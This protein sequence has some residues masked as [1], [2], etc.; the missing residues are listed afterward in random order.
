MTDT[1]INI[2]QT[3]RMRVVDFARTQLLPAANP[4]TSLEVYEPAKDVPICIHELPAAYP[5]EDHDDFFNGGVSDSNILR[6]N[7]MYLRVIQL[8]EQDG[9]LGFG[10]SLAS[11]YSL[12]SRG[13]NAAIESNDFRPYFL[14]PG[15]IA[16]PN[17]EHDYKERGW[18]APGIKWATF[19]PDLLRFTPNGH[20]RVT[21][22]I[23]RY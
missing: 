19:R 5:F 20:G 13:A 12:F 16:P 1:S 11:M 6:G 15:T 17:V 18:L 4:P 9:V 2:Q 22:D 21:L 7:M 3:H 23:I 10:K 8:L 14:C